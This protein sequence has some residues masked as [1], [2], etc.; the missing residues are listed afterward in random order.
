MMQ[1]CSCKEP[2]RGSP[3]GLEQATSSPDWSRLLSPQ[4][5]LLNCV[6][7]LQHRNHRNRF[8]SREPVRLN[9]L[10]EWPTD[11][12]NGLRPWDATSSLL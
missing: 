10:L 4:S 12:R 3:V 7:A 11:I 5:C 1:F 6:E 8:L 9:V 2:W